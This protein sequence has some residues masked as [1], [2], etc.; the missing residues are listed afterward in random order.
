MYTFITL[1]WG[2]G[3]DLI[4]IHKNLL[5]CQIAQYLKLFLPFTNF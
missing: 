3:I 5:I 2:Q 4:P 1:T